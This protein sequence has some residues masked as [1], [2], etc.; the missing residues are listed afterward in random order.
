MIQTLPDL[1]LWLNQPQALQ[2]GR[3]ERTYSL[4]MLRGFADESYRGLH[5][6][7]QVDIPKKNGGFRRLCIP[8]S[9]LKALQRRLLPL[10]L[11]AQNSLPASAFAYRCQKTLRQ[12]AACHAGCSLLVKLD[13][14]SFFDSVSFGAVFRAVD[15]ALRL[16]PLVAAA[17]P[18][19]SGDVI[20]VAQT[21]RA[22]QGTPCWCNRQLSWYIA[23]FCTRQGSLPQGAPTSPLLSNLVFAPLDLRIE[24]YCQAKG[25]TYTRYADDLIFSFYAAAPGTADSGAASL[26]AFVRSLLLRSG[27]RLNEEKTV[28]AG[29][30]RRRVVTGAVVHETLQAPASYRKKLRQEIYYIG[31][32]GLREH[33]LHTNAFAHSSGPG[34]EAQSAEAERVKM[35]RAAQSL[36]GR[37][38]FVLQLNP[39]D[40]EFQQYH[41]DCL[42]L[43]HAVY[44]L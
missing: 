20:S 14:C 17:V 19:Q 29:V 4:R 36:L 26:I 34:T 1:L 42:H 44:R 22:A 43:L 31:K 25:I 41:K 9:D 38:S 40:R 33:L 28:V 39:S 3:C 10:F 12:H 23:Q 2:S 21:G 6:Y 32:Y 16:S 8:R 18:A 5:C 35:I 13:L 15:D 30:G 24:A 27:Y 7:R 11:P 37:V